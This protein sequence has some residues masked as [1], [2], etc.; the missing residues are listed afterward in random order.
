MMLSARRTRASFIYIS[1]AR[2]KA[3]LDVGEGGDLEPAPA[4]VRIGRTESEQFGAKRDRGRFGSNAEQSQPALAGPRHKRYRTGQVRP[5]VAVTA[6][7]CDF[8]VPRAA[9]NVDQQHIM[10]GAHRAL[11]NL[12]CR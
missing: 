7:G 10:R 11:Y 9:M 12:R 6:I 2:T 5:V 8:K 4:A 1:G 3:V